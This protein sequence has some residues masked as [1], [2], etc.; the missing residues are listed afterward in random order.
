MGNFLLKVLNFAYFV[1]G[2]KVRGD[3]HLE[4]NQVHPPFP[5]EYNLEMGLY[6]FYFEEQFFDVGGEDISAVHDNHVVGPSGNT[7]DSGGSSAAGAFPLNHGGDIPGS[8]PD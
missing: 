6:S 7:L 2:E 8:V 5:G 3:F 4:F 1:K